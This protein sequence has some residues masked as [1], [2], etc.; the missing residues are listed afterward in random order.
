MTKTGSG[1][2]VLTGANTYTGATTIS[3]GTL[4]LG[5]GLPSQDGSLSSGTITD[6]SALVYDLN[7]SQAYAGLLKGPG[8]L[9]QNRHGHPDPQPYQSIH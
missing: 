5:T 4:Q 2:V 9:T 3:G 6:N 8:A 7:G 1:T